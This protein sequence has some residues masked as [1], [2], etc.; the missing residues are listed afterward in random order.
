[1]KMTAQ[2]F[3]EFVETIQNTAAISENELGRAIGVTGT[4]IRWWKR[5]GLPVAKTPMIVNRL[6]QFMRVVML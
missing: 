3:K 1:M 6:R 4:S 2:H 5:C